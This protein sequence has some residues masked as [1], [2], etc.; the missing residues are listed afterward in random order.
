MINTI[1]FDFGGVFTYSPFT[2][3][4]AAG[5]AKGAQPGQFTEIMFGAYHEDGDHPW[6]RLER[7]EITIEDARQGILALGQAQDLEVDL[8]E[9][10]A[11]LPRDGGLRTELVDK[12]GQLKAAGYRLAIITNNVREF[13][14][15]WRSMMPV[16]ELFDE[17]IDSCMEGIRK[18]SPRIFELAL[19][20]MGVA[21]VAHALFLDDYPANIT[22]AEQLG[23]RSIL[24][25]E[26]SARVI[27][28]IDESL[29]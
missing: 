1:F 20:R 28:E 19:E 26:D 16:D 15:A 21:D 25:D 3:V 5:V 8:Y 23:I 27:A 2:A 6:H 12:V 4:D 29:S 22:A 7:G 18:P 13:S 24:V 10:F 14:D 9:I 17:V 11:S